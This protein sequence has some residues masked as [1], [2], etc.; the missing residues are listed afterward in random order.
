MAGANRIR[1]ISDSF[2]REEKNG[3]PMRAGQAAVTCITHNRVLGEDACRVYAA[4]AF[5]AL[6]D[7][8]HALHRMTSGLLK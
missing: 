8:L 1:F 4:H 5:R 6:Q 3:P 2:V 7:C